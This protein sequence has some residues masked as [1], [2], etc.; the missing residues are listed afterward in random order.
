MS[1]MVERVAEA[2]MRVD[3]DGKISDYYK[4][5][6][7]AIEAMREPTEEMRR[8]G[9]E[10]SPHDVGGCRDQIESGREWMKLAVVGPY[11]A[12]IDEALK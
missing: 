6:R 5:A 2:I 4:W 12:M 10:N 8:A 11:Q 9:F 7:A 3:A 1:E